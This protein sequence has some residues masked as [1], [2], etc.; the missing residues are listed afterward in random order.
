MLW[1]CACVRSNC[2][3]Y[4]S[5]WGFS[6]STGYSCFGGFRFNVS[7]YK[8]LSPNNLSQTFS[9]VIIEESRKTQWSTAK[10][11]QQICLPST[12]VLYPKEGWYTAPLPHLDSCSPAFA[13]HSLHN[14]TSALDHSHIA[15]FNPVIMTSNQAIPCNLV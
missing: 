1:N 5:F 9:M 2:T 10:D 6:N 8:E 11:L 12:Q 13:K 4:S 14:V 3:G 15:A 7:L